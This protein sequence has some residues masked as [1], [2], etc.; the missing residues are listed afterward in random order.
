MVVIHAHP[1]VFCYNLIDSKIG[2]DYKCRPLFKIH[3][4]RMKGI[5]RRI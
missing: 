1:Q 5:V 3:M 4:N 2:V